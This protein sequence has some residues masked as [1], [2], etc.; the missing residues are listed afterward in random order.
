MHTLPDSVRLVLPRLLLK[1]TPG[2]GA[3]IAHQSGYSFYG[4]PPRWHKITADKPAP[5]GAP[6]AAHP[7]AGGV[8]SP[9]E[10]YTPEQ[11][12][13]LKLPESNVNAPS[14]NKALD[15]LKEWS[16]SGNVTAILGAGFGTNTY[17]KKLAAIANSLLAAHGSTH[18]VAAGQKAGE[19]GAVLAAPAGAKPADAASAD[20]PLGAYSAEPVEAPAIGAVPD[21]FKKKP[22]PAAP[23]PDLDSPEDMAADHTK[24]APAAKPEH[25]EFNTGDV[26]KLD[27]QYQ[28]MNAGE[29]TVYNISPDGTQVYMHKVGAKVP[30]QTN[31]ATIPA[32]TL[33]A[34]IAKGTATKVDPGAPDHSAHDTSASKV[35]HVIPSSDPKAGYEVHVATPK[36]KPGS[37]FSVAIKDVD[38][39]EF[40]PSVKMFPTESAALD[41][42]HA[43]ADGKKPG[44]GP[45][46]G[47]TKPAAD[48]GTLVLKDGHWVKQGEPAPTGNLSMPD[49]QEGKTVTGVKALY[50]KVAQKLIDHAHA[51]NLSVIEDMPEPAKKMW[52]GKTPNSK[53]L[54]ALHAEAVA[55]LKGSGVAGIDPEAKAPEPAPA[56]S[57]APSK[58]AQIPWAQQMLPT[59]NSNAASHNKA[60]AKI[61]AMAEAGD[62]AG[63]QAFAD[64]KA[65]AKQTYAKK[66]GLLAQLALA[67]L[68]EDAPAAPAPAPAAEKV[69]ELTPKQ[70]DGLKGWFK[71]GKPT[72]KHPDS[73]SN[74]WS[75]LSPGMKAAVKAELEA[76]DPPVEAVQPPSAASKYPVVDE[77][78]AA[79]TAGKVPTKAQAEAYEALTESDPDAAQEAF[80]DAVNSLIPPEHLNDDDKFDESLQAAYEKAHELHGKGL[81][82]K[83][84][85]APQPVGPAGVDVSGLSDAEK[86]VIYKLISDNNL[87]ALKDVSKYGANPAYKKAA[88]EALAALQSAQKAK[89]QPAPVTA[90]TPLGRKQLAALE[91][92]SLD[93]LTAIKDSEGLPINVKA[94]IDKKL[95][96]SA[97]PKTVTA[98]KE[99]F[100]NTQPGHSKS[101]SVYVAPNANGGYDM[102]AE[103][104]KIGGTQKKTVTPF[105]TLDAAIAAKKTKIKSKTANGYSLQHTDFSHKVTLSGA[106]VP[107]SPAKDALGGWSHSES[108]PGMSGMP[109]LANDDGL[110][111]F[112]PSTGQAEYHN[113]ASIEAG[114][115]EPVLSSSSLYTLVHAMAANGHPVPPLA[116]IQKLAPSFKA[117]EMPAGPKEGD[118]KQGA[119]GMLVLKN[120]HWVKVSEDK[121]APKQIKKLDSLQIGVIIQSITPGQAKFSSNAHG[122]MAMKAAMAGD[123]AAMAVAYAKAAQAMKFPKT[124]S[125]IKA[126]AEAMGVDTSSWNAPTTTAP[127]PLVPETFSGSA[128]AQP[129]APPSV[130]GW[131][132]TG[133]QGG[134]NPGGKFKDPNGDEWYVKWPGD[135]EAV[136]SEILAAKLY[137]LAGLASQDCMLVTKGGKTA[138][139]TKWVN[140]SKA[141]SAAA[142]AKVDGVQSGFAVDAWLGNWD[143]IGMSLDNLQVGPDGKAHRVDAGGSLEY[144][145]QG[146]KKPFGPKV[147]E[148]DTLRDA[149]KNPHAA[150]VFGKMT[151]ADITASVAKVASIDDAAIR[152]LVHDHGPGNEAQKKALADTLIARK[153]DLLA[154]YPKAAK[155]A[156]KPLDPTALPVD[157]KSLPKPHDFSNWNGPGQGLSSKGHVNKANEAV[158]YQMLGLA[159]AGNMVAVEGFKFAEVNKDTGA[160]TG[161][162]LPIGQ[163]PSKHVQQ[164]Q[165]DLLQVLDEVANPPQPLKVFRS[166][167]VGSLSALA[168]AFPPKKFGTTVKNVQ[169]NEKLGFWV[170]LGAVGNPSKFKPKVL[171]NYTS[172]AVA[173]AKQ[174][175]A[176]ASAL[177]KHF[178]KSVQASGSYNDLF[179]DGKTHDSAGNSL[180][181]VAKAA[182]AH[183]TEMPEGTCLYRWQKMSPQ[184]LEHIMSAKEGTVF[185]ATGPMCTSYDP[186]ATSGFGTH[187]VKVVYAP[188]AKAVESFASGGFAGEKEVTTLPNARFVILSKQMVPDVEHGNASGKRLEL[189]VLM[190]PPDLGIQ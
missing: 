92:L 160:P 28:K 173:K 62:V 116:A 179:R 187:R 35:L 58:L 66:Q 190:L 171:T 94:W 60:V 143:V 186:T 81:F 182:L 108:D 64:A 76:E 174:K 114:D 168:A 7:E 184:M 25:F 107:Q 117:H 17:G 3:K 20:A 65:G 72:S 13:Q 111:A 63:L 113:N 105:S 83:R 165:Q 162:M 166:T 77:W 79:I 115:G 91:S 96:A 75:K 127:D 88:G 18:K 100:H 176:T 14:Y 55:S 15:K 158:E 151:E 128:A 41:H 159:Q 93:E 121:P 99:V 153:N 34:A 180:K 147:D 29:W 52:Q 30:N 50:E 22:E 44:T 123:A 40:L 74:L 138:I 155:P 27:S 54:L 80:M 132:Q 59:S 103:H 178:I 45:K 11:W 10:H 31:S 118:T 85:P 37:K 163:H 12:A 149:K 101:W 133:G 2:S 98:V 95:A 124:A 97:S 129:E 131:A 135:A 70:I 156:K 152:A 68:K 154:R 141:N 164:Y 86:Q 61:Q 1:S 175:Y 24:P 122:K 126:V 169:S 181:D 16:D 150:A 4:H 57:G 148:I 39:G 188:G 177:A 183:A 78:K 120:G 53:K 71:A 170:A 42:A 167:E 109:T 172:A 119:D 189:E 69:T 21:K 5:K 112:D 137:A 46:E 82:G 51:G 33:A 185:Q 19:H 47:D 48:G 134:S 36:S 146:E 161:K 145:A 102:V 43:L 125:H 9:A 23:L 140:L 49:F 32:S 157:P 90:D 89:A 139:A 26:F 144:R 73:W 130:D 67:A 136:K 56:A 104:G 84:E 106:A 8:H 6:V 38:S 87:D 142:L 110:I